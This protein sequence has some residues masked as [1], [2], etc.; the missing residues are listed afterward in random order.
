MDEK[1]HYVVATGIVIKDGKYLIAKRADYE[2]AFPG[3]WTVPG[4]K[5][6]QKDYKNR[7]HDTDAGQWYNVVEDLLRREVMEEVGLEMDKINYLASLTFVRPDGIPSLVL[8]M[9]AEYKS[10]EVKLGEGLTEYAWVTLEDAKNYKLIQGIYE[11][12]EM[13]DKSLK[14]KKIGEWGKEEK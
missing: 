11:E 1:I 10:G 2:K 6:E 12:L 9:F 7:K 5:L 8:S 4:G 14:G 3:L 13:L